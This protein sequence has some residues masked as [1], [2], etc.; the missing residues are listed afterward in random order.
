MQIY[1]AHTKEKTAD[2]V[3]NQR[4]LVKP[5]CG[6]QLFEVRNQAAENDY[7]NPDQQ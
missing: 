5:Q 4:F 3:S 2:Y 7:A 1:P 6:S